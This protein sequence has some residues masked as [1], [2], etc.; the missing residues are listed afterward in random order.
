MPDGVPLA[1]LT[2]LRLGGPARTLREVDDEEQLIRAVADA[3][4]RGEPLLVLGGGSNLL[5]GDDG[6]PGTVVVVRTRGVRV[7][8]DADAGAA[9][10]VEVAAG[11]PWD[12][13]VHRAVESGWAGV[14]CLS[15]IPGLTG[16]TPIQNV[17]AYGQEVADTLVSV[18]AYDRRFRQVVQ[19]AAMDCGLGYRTSRFRSD[20]DG[21]VLL[22]VTF[23]LAFADRSASVRYAELA[24]VLDVSLGTRVPLATAR[25]AVLDLRRRKGMVLDAAD[26]D[27]WSA[28]S[29]FT[30]PVLSRAAY[31]QLSERAGQRWGED[32]RPPAYPAGNDSVKTSAAWLVERAGFVRGYGSGAARVSTKHALALTHRG[33]GT[34]ADLVALA[35]EIRAG[36]HAKF[37]I[38]LEPEPVLIGV[39]L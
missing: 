7:D 3:D 27:T 13:V 1:P 10:T 21:H 11:E 4:D 38:L 28:G 34:S 8:A 20:R 14:E 2:T 12:D 5:I 17:G 22:S 32:A 25:E 16:A 39:T 19:I 6:F 31:E 18:R 29:F 26:R 15:G 35:R 30:N 9:V 24:R 23:R 37:D 33:G 36:V